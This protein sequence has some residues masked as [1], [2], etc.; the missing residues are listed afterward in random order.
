MGF[1]QL[2]KNDIQEIIADL[3]RGVIQSEGKHSLI[4]SKKN[5]EFCKI[6]LALLA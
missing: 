4:N 2:N 5:T 1:K 3:H 6:K